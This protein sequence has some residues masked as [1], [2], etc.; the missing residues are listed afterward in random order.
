ME[1]EDTIVTDE[2]KKH[3]ARTVRSLLPHGPIVVGPKLASI[4]RG[5]GI[6][7]ND[8]PSPRTPS[9]YYTASKDHPIDLSW[10]QR[11]PLEA[12]KKAPL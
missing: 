3:L 10:E 12:L 9:G 6:V 11:S 2:E 4:L 8:L 1:E 5:A 7:V